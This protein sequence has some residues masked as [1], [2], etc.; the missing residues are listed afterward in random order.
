[1]KRGCVRERMGAFDR[2]PPAARHALANA[3]FDWSPRSAEAMIAK[4]GLSPPEA[5]RAIAR[6]DR[7][8]LQRPAHL[9]CPT[10]R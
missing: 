9:P 2:L 1:M 4:R 3:V 10:K 5:A 8:V 6:A 7:K